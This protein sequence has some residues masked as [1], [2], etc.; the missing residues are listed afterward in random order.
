MKLPS[1]HLCEVIVQMLLKFSFLKFFHIA[2][3]DHYRA[4]TCQRNQIEEEKTP[5]DM[6][7][8]SPA[9]SELVSVR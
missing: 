9:A 4:E 8:L 6:Q 7:A 3:L 5:Q 2:E 1:V